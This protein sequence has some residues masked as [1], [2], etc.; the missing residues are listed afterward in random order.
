M[1]YAIALTLKGVMDLNDAQYLWTLIG[2]G[3]FATAYTAVGGLRAVIWTDVLQAVTLGAAVVVVLLLA[4]CRIDGG[5]GG[6]WQIG[7]EHGR[8]TMFHLDP[9]LLAPQNFTAQELGLHGRG[10]LPVHVPAGLRGGA[11]HDPAL[12]LYR[13]RAPGAG[14]GGAQR[15]INAGLGFLFLLVGVALFAFYT[16]PGGAGH[17]RAGKRGPDPA[18]FRLAPKR[19]ASGWSG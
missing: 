13:R 18:A 5:W 2:L 16:Q 12:R 15:L 4:V 14:R 6:L 7:Q 11:E 17:A 1:L 19:P 3:V 8:W 10:L 9:H